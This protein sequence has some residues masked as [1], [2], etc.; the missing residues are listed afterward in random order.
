MNFLRKLC[1]YPDGDEERNGKGYISMY[2]AIAETDA[3]AVGWEVHVKFQLFVFD[4]IQDK[5]LEVEGIIIFIFFIQLH[6]L[7]LYIYNNFLFFI[8]LM[9][10][11]MIDIF[12]IK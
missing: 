10:I 9:Y 8:I 6:V 7:C 12:Y 1:L 3:L 11:K 4:H 5:F 2:L